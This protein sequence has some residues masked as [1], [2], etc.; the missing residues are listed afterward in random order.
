VLYTLGRQ[1]DTHP[2]QKELVSERCTDLAEQHT[3]VPHI[4]ALW[5]GNWSAANMST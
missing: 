4:L 3:V 5:A 2:M 1:L